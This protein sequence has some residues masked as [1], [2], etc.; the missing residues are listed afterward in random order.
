MTEIE[1]GI[2]AVLTGAA[3][4]DVLGATW[5]FRSPEDIPQR[6]RLAVQG[7]GPFAW[8]PG[9][10]TDD[11]DLLLAAAFSYGERN[12]AP[13]FSEEGFL[14]R[15]LDWF[16]AGPRDVGMQ[17]GHACHH[18]RRARTP[19]PADEAAQGNGGLMRAAP[20]GLLHADAATAWAA[21]AAD[22]R[23]THPSAFAAACSGFLAAVLWRLLW[24]GEAEWRALLASLPPSPAHERLRR[25]LAALSPGGPPPREEGGWCLHTLRLAL[26]ALDSGLDYEEAIQRV[27]RTGGDTDT[28]ACVAGALLG[29]RWG[30]AAI[31]RDW[32]E[33]ITPEGQARLEAATRH[34]AGLTPQA[35]NRSS[36]IL[37]SSTV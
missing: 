6:G 18:W 33:A 28:N 25:H 13:A 23:L 4:G 8:P 37:P 15:L 35:K 9:A 32:A 5:E 17:T 11:T 3:V 22:T 2:R 34:L 24:E 31:P 14:A 29:A 20:H 12:G 1:T 26:W 16:A 19:L 21:A 30:L 27:I 10:F 36:T 7:G